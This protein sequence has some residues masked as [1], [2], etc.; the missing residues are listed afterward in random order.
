MS[1]NRFI[2]LID[3]GSITDPHGLKDSYRALVMRTHP[4]HAGNSRIEEY[5]R[6]EDDYQEALQFLCTR[7]G[8]TGI[9]EENVRLLFFQELRKIDGLE[10]PYCLDKDLAD[11]RLRTARSNAER[12]FRR[13]RGESTLFS[14][15]L[16]EHDVLKHEK[17]KNSLA[18]LYKPRDFERIRPL[19]FSLT[20]YHL[21]GQPFYRIQVKR[22][23]TPVLQLLAKR[24]LTSL[25]S[26]YAL[27]ADDI[28]NG[29]AIEG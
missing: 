3:S 1:D 27:L 20:Y 25:H 5:L 8:L 28:T 24:G 26:Y 2:N 7:A 6:L 15:M 19:S 14:E 21:T 13:W 23:R 17:K 22:L 29:P 10:S 18:E 9:G 16:V 12:Y 11:E 4:D